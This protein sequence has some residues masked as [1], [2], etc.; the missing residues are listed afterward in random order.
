MFVRLLWIACFS[1]PATFTIAAEPV[2][3]IE[4]AVWSPGDAS[5]DGAAEMD[6]LL[7]LAQLQHA[8]RSV[9]LI[10]VGDRRGVFQE[11]TQRG[12]EFAIQRGVPVVRLARESVDA[13]LA[14]EDGW[15]IDGGSMS[16]NAAAALLNECLKR[17]G[18][19]PKLSSLQQPS[20][21]ELR[22]F[23]AKLR[24][25]QTE[26]SARQPAMVAMR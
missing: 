19:L 10:G 8:H 17:Y 5:R 18:S 2:A 1:L 23:R 25:F 3:V 15:F 9:G 21:S 13:P 6:V 11:G 14:R 20:A 12:F 7:K 4:D 26:F 24:L 22:A 16:A